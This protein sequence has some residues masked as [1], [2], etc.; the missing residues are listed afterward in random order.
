M[1][2]SKAKVAL[3]ELLAGEKEIPTFIAHEKIIAPATMNFNDHKTTIASSLKRDL[4]Y[5]L[6]SRNIMKHWAKKQKLPV[7]TNTLELEV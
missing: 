4:A 1:T 6:T 5:K 7:D 3:R 2:D